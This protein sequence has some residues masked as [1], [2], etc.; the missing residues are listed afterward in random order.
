M[1]KLQREGIKFGFTLI[2]IWLLGLTGY[3]L[4][5]KMNTGS[6]EVGNTL[7]LPPEIEI[8]EVDVAPIVIGEE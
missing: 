2:L 4:Y 1:N 7:I 8:L 6:K 5:D 3:L